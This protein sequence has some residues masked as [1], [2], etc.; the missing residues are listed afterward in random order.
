MADRHLLRSPTRFVFDSSLARWRRDLAC[1]RPDAGVVSRAVACTARFGLA[2]RDTF[3]YFK[4]VPRA[5]LAVSP[6]LCGRQ[7]M[8]HFREPS[9]QLPGQRRIGRRVPPLG[10]GS[11]DPRQASACP[12]S[13]RR[14]ALDKAGQPT[15]RWTRYPTE[16]FIPTLGLSRGWQAAWFIRR[17]VVITNLGR[18]GRHPAQG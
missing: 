16:S 14:N 11:K 5:V 4:N 8:E 7:E 15:R 10:G 2:R 12:S 17:R 6:S 1:S 13:Y 18:R 9:P 3:S